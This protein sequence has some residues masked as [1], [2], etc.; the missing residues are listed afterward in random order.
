MDITGNNGSGVVIDGIRC[1]KHNAFRSSATSTSGGT[2]HYHNTYVGYGDSII[3]NTKSG[4]EDISIAPFLNINSDQLDDSDAYYSATL[5]LLDFYNHYEQGTLSSYS[6]FFNMLGIDKGRSTF[7]HVEF[8]GILY[9]TTFT[10]R[11]ALPSDY[12]VS[13]V[14]D[15]SMTASTY[16]I[17]S[18]YNP[19]QKSN[20]ILRFQVTNKMLKFP[21]LSTKYYFKMSDINFRITISKLYTVIENA[22]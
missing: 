17:R 16:Y 2:I 22:D 1:N 12:S 10:I 14:P 13:I 21:K 18:G 3:S 5:N 7:T 15:S 4:D 6:T 9:Y 8:G 11:C 20:R 19:I